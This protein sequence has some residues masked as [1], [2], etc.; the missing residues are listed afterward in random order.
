VDLKSAFHH[1]PLSPAL[2]A[3]CSVNINGQPYSLTVVSF[4]L[5]IAPKIFTEVLSH[6]LA[7]LRAAGMRF[8]SY[9]DDILIASPSPQQ[10]A[11][12]LLRLVR[13]SS[14]SGS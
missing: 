14:N 2:S 3:L 13:P 8:L 1:I 12:D 5:S 4:G 11:Q 7:P 9:M 10:A 6:A